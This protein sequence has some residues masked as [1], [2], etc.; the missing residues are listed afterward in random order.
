MAVTQAQT[1][2]QVRATFLAN[3]N[4]RS[5]KTPRQTY[6]S[7]QTQYQFT[8]PKAGYGIYAVIDFQGTLTIAGSGGSVSVSPK[9]PFNLFS[10]VDFEDFLGTH[11]VQASGWKLYEREIMTALAYDPQNGQS[12]PLSNSET[13]TLQE[14]SI[15]GSGGAAGS[16]PLNTSVILPIALHSNTT[17]GSFPF[18]IP[19][20]QNQVTV[21]IGSLVGSTI[22]NL[23]VQATS[24]FTVTLS[25]TIG[26]E[27]YYWDVPTGTVLPAQDFALVHELREI[28]QNE[29]IMAGMDL[30]FSLPTGRTYFAIMQD[31]VLN[32]ALNDT[33]ITNI[34]FLVDGDTP[35]LDEPWYNYQRRIKKQYNRSMP[36]GEFVFDFWRKPWTPDNYGSL[37]TVLSI[38][39]GATVGTYYYTSLLLESMYT[40]S[41][42]V[43]QAG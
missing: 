5:Q 28:K 33:D 31:M 11:R 6:D 20:G 34:K 26:I 21:S 10:W 23:L 38:S 32:G 1:L 43:A 19:K 41:Q 9:A 22:D 18:A 40:S 27:Y 36:I 17:Q 12:T 2:G 13:S 35:M 7:S 39:S 37:Q 16:Y 8:L 15:G 14:I 29:N 3:A 42:V 24:G 25:G 30:L 4:I